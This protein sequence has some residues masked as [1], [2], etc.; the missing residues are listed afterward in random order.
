MKARNLIGVN[1]FA[2]LLLGIEVIIVLNCAPVQY[3]QE[4]VESSQYQQ[5]VHRLLTN[6][7]L[8]FKVRVYLADKYKPGNCVGMPKI[9]PK[10][11]VRRVLRDS[12][13]LVEYIRLKY[14]ITDENGIFKKMSQINGIILEKNEKGFAFRFDDGQCC[15]IIHAYGQVYIENGEIV[16]CV[17][18]RRIKEKVPC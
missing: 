1:I 4:K 8:K 17:I 18:L 2:F 13:V 10:R 9:F 3:P 14:H 16:D 7:P 15:K 6:P 5:D 11:Y 12:P